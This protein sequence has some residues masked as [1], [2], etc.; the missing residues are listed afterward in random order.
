LEMLG[1]GAAC[2]VIL[3]V[4][5]SSRLRADDEGR[6]D[7]TLAAV[8]QVLANHGLTEEVISKLRS[9][10]P[11]EEIDY[12]LLERIRDHVTDYPSL[13]HDLLKHEGNEGKN[14]RLA[15]AGQLLSTTVE[16]DTATAVVVEIRADGTQKRKTFTLRRNNGQWRLFLPMPPEKRSPTAVADEVGAG[17]RDR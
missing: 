1:T 11:D 9:G 5:V 15:I 7:P 3:A 12:S 16:G 4:E 8:K 6:E 17:R 13:L 14:L 10:P 2:Q